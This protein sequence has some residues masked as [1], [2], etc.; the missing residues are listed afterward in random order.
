M[1]AQQ[2]I[3]GFIAANGM[4]GDAEIRYYIARENAAEFAGAQGSVAP[5][6]IP[7][8]AEVADM[9]DDLESYLAGKPHTVV[10]E[11]VTEDDSR[12]TELERLEERMHNGGPA[13]TMAEIE[14]L[15][16]RRI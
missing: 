3:S 16:E 13:M 14:E 4:G 12:L 9:F 15:E 2:F 7:V 8:G 10:A 1:A 5:A 11:D 6:A